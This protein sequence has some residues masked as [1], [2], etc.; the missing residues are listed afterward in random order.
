MRPFIALMRLTLLLG[1][2]PAA[3]AQPITFERSYDYDHG[4]S[5]YCVIQTSD[6][7]YLMAG[8]QGI[9]P[10]YAKGL[11]IKTDAHGIEQWHNMFWAG[12][13]TYIHDV[14]ELDDGGFIIVGDHC[15]PAMASNIFLARTDEFGDTL[16]LRSFGTPGG[17][18]A[19]DVV[20]MPDGGF[21]LSV[22]W[23]ITPSKGSL[24]R[25]D[26]QG[27][28]I[29]QQL[30][31]PEGATESVFESLSMADDGTLYMCGT[32]HFPDPARENMLYVV[33]VDAHGNLL[34]ERWFGGPE[35]D[36]G[37]TVAAIP[38]GGAF[39]AGFTWS[40]GAGHYDMYLIRLTEE[41]DT[42]WTTTVG[43]ENEETASQ[44]MA[45]PDGGA[46][47]FGTTYAGIS[48]QGQYKFI[49]ARISSDG[50]LGWSEQFGRPDPHS[51]YGYG[52]CA[53]QDGGYALCGGSHY[54]AN[55]I[56]TNTRG[57]LVGIHDPAPKSE[58]LQLYPNPATDVCHVR[59]PPAWAA[60]GMVNI[61]VVNMVGASVLSTTAST[62][63][64]SMTLTVGHLSPGLYT[65]RFRTG[66][67]QF[68]NLKLIVR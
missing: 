54:D 32:A 14:K 30:Y 60:A 17:D 50:E 22:T 42:L 51:M 62:Q 44:V 5:A 15:R 63:E 24:I 27:N 65:V 25:T 55:L 33:R 2:G 38:G 8:K 21:L 47:L 41:G 49:L 56:K 1:F 9:A 37:M 18:Y 43:T 12:C 68:S 29:W 31:M 39:A 4:E 45:L 11:L 6:G 67:Q 7:G 53:A 20:V 40:F 48:P 23:G 3:L 36:Q 52:A 28:V 64:G 13:D 57:Q 19:R 35:N 59:F 16:W 34:W 66:A 61:D 46:V 58:G 26:E 10:F